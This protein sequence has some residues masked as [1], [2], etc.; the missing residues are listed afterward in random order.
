MG[1]RVSAFGYGA[2]IGTL[3]GLIGLGGAEFRLP[4]IM[5]SFNFAAHK[6]VPLNLLIS[7]ITIAASLGFRVT[8][9][10]TGAVEPHMAEIMGLIAGGVTAAWFGAGLLHRMSAHALERVIAL[11]LLFIAGLLLVEAVLPFGVGVEL[12]PAAALRAAA[13]VGFGI[14]IGLVSSMLGV[15]GG[16]LIIPTL[17]VVFGLDIK[18]AGTASLLI[19]L[20]TVLVGV[21]RHARRRAY[22]DTTALGHVAAPM[23]FGSILGAF[24]GASVVGLVPMPA[25]KAALG[26]VLI[27]SGVK[28]LSRI[29]KQNPQTVPEA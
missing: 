18:T 3:G 23:G 26:M 12:P 5:G 19:S 20:P 1:R 7:L 25:L 28:M 6:A 4:V 15:A 11:L 9:F 24:I 2:A 27:T 8:V 22:A 29:R 13:G 16:E 17:V 10:P 21:I 14:V